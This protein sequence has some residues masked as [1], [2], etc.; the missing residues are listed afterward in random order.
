MNERYAA[1]LASLFVKAY[2]SAKYDTK[3]I[4]DYAAGLLLSPEEMKQIP[5][6][7]LAGAVHI[8]KSTEDTDE[9]LAKMV[10][11]F[12]SPPVMA[13]SLFISSALENA[14]QIGA[15]QYLM[16]GSGYDTFAYTQ[17]LWATKMTIFE[18]DDPY[19]IRDKRRRLDFAG[20]TAPSNVRYL[21]VENF[22]KD[23]ASTLRSN[24]VYYSDKVTFCSVPYTTTILDKENL[25]KLLNSLY[26][27]L[28]SGSSIAFDF[29]NEI[30]PMG[31]DASF[32]EQLLDYCGYRLYEQ[33]S[34]EELTSRFFSEYN[35]S[36]PQYPIIAPM[37]MNYYLAVKK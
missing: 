22:A 6:S 25:E 5:A 2:H 29:P 4:D 27:Y 21:A 19:I 10:N 7:L 16:F 35:D 11:T 32:I 24:L 8:T 9:L 3:I 18:I 37:N 33:A 31:F 36:N 34:H 13:S 17:P 30:V 28:T 12:L 20:I 1:A 14:A 23:I 15:K 26:P